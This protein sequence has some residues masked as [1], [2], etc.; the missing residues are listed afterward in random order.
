MC[1][2]LLKHLSGQGGGEGYGDGSPGPG[3]GP[4]ARPLGGNQTG[5]VQYTCCFLRHLL[6]AAFPAAVT[7]F[8]LLLGG[9]RRRP[10]T[11]PELRCHRHY[12]IVGGL[13]VGPVFGAAGS[14]L[15]R[16]MLRRG[17]LRLRGHGF[18]LLGVEKNAAWTK[19]KNPLHDR[20]FRAKHHETCDKVKHE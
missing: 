6:G 13:R 18:L 14:G 19:K 1:A 2:N 8:R 7:Q 16:R 17:P 10:G 5:S 12:A 3:P 15:G 20:C 4:G 11:G 9:R